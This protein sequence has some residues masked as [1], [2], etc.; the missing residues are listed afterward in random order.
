MK[1]IESQSRYLHQS[2]HQFLL[3]SLGPREH[4][5]QYP[6][7]F[8]VFGEPNQQGYRETASERY[9]RLH[10]LY[11]DIFGQMSLTGGGPYGLANLNDLLPMFGTREIT[12]DE[13]IWYSDESNARL[14]HTFLS[15]KLAG[16]NLAL[17]LVP[18]GV[19][20]DVVARDSRV[21]GF[22]VQRSAHFL[23]VLIERPHEN[24]P[25]GLI[26]SEK[27]PFYQPF[28]HEDIQQEFRRFSGTWEKAVYAVMRKQILPDDALE[29]HGHKSNID[30]VFM[31]GHR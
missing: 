22:F 20:A 28:R 9:A 31:Q 10:K 4:L 12:G 29:S 23:P 7:N 30:G 15:D 26:Y 5:D 24:L 13:M 6:I 25:T 17:L 1:Q 19:S 2:V 27:Q 3:D 14:K 21:I 8:S 16:H 11:R 18:D